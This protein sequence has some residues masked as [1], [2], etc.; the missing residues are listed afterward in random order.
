MN[1]EDAKILIASTIRQKPSILEAFLLSLKELDITDLAVDFL[2]VDNNDDNR[3]TDMIKSFVLEGSTVFW[4]PE[5]PIQEYLCNENTHHWNDDLIWKIATYKNGILRFANT[6]KYSH[7]LMIDSDLVLHPLTLKQLLSAEKDIISEIFWTEWTP[8]AGELPQVWMSGQ[9]AFYKGSSTMP[10]NEKALQIRSVLGQLKEP[11]IYEVGGLGA[12]TLISLKAIQA[13]V[14]Y[15]QIP[16]VDYWG[17]DRHFGIRAAVLGFG[18]YVD[19]HYPALHLYR[20]TDLAKVTAYKKG[21][22]PV[23]KPWQRKSRDNKITLS[24]V[25]RNEAGRCLRKMLEQTRQ[26]IDAAVIIDDASTDN[27]PE[28][29]REMLKNIPLTLIK[30]EQSIFSQEYI[31]R[32]KQWQETVKTNPDWILVLDADEIMEE[33]TAQLLPQLINQAEVDVWSFQLFDFWDAEHYRE[34]GYWQAHRYFRPFLARYIP[35]FSYKWLETPQHCGRFPC[36]VMHLKNKP[37]PLRV[38][39]Y[40]WATPEFREEKYNR[41]LKLDPEGKYGIKAQYESILDSKPHLIKWIE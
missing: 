23:S 37:A 26:F 31:L 32:Q 19:T 12:C 21:H 28:L 17:E 30:N 3:S 2:F 1:T 4:A 14:H 25:V 13:G 41:Y 36:N 9:Y 38:K 24:M 29:C 18:L 6:Q 16:N 7:V 34:D 8:G 27:T 10:V 40:G 22:A 20:E 5:K 15:D 11:G 33:K 35:S 39:H